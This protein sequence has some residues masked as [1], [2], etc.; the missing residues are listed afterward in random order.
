LHKYK[1]VR[2]ADLPSTQIYAR[3]L[4]ATRAA[5][6]HIAILADMQSAGIGK[7][8][9]KFV[10]PKGNLYFSCILNEIRDPRAAYCVALAASDAL[11]ECKVPNKVKWPN[12]VYAGGGKI[13][14][15]I[16][17]NMD[18][19]TIIGVG[20]N[21]INKPEFPDYPTSCA[22]DLGHEIKRDDILNVLLDSLDFWLDTL[23]GGDF[24]AIRAEWLR[25]AAW[26][27]EEV[28]YKDAPAIF[29]GIDETGALTIEQND[30]QIRIIGTES[31]IKWPRNK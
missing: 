31:P 14:G 30:E 9:N 25:R 15:S 8:G 4:V 28:L 18:G 29:T 13:S 16:I 7:R 21:L 10:S 23:A 24:E 6:D 22:L 27:D 19:F 1:V 20:V 26:L 17:D 2:F 12:D 5:R 3:D 11:L